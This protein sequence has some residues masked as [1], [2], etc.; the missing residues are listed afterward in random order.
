LFKIKKKKVQQNNQQSDEKKKR[1]RLL[2]KLLDKKRSDL[3]EIRGVDF[4]AVLRKLPDNEEMQKL[5]FQKMLFASVKP[6]STWLQYYAKA[7]MPD[8]V[9]DKLQE[10]RKDME[11]ILVTRLKNIIF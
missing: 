10:H 9:W 11:L 8:S 5:Y 1:Q 3:I 6:Q 7:T 2:D 4:G